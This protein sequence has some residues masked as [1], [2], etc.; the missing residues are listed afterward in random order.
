MYELGEKIREGEELLDSP[1]WQ[2][3]ISTRRTLFAFVATGRYIE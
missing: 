3:C 2:V 1:F